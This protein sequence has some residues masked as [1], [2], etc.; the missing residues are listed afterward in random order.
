MTLDISDTGL[1]YELANGTFSK[2][3]PM[4]GVASI[5][6]ME[7]SDGSLDILGG[8]NIFDVLVPASEATRGREISKYD[9]IISDIWIGQV[10]KYTQGKKTKSQAIKDFKALVK[11]QLDALE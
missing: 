6:V 4:E 7:R 10:D 9:D 3:R 2:D 1:Q 5:A 11:E 8:Q